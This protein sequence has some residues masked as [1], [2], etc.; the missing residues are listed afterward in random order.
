MPRSTLW[1]HTLRFELILAT[2]GASLWTASCVVSSA[3]SPESDA[4]DGGGA[5]SGGAAGRA[6]AMAGSAGSTEVAG[7][8]GATALDAGL[9]PLDGGGQSDGGPDPLE[10]ACSAYCAGVAS[11]NDRGDAGVCDPTFD[12]E[13]CNLGCVAVGTGGDPDCLD[14]YTAQTACFATSTFS[15]RAQFVEVDL[16]PCLSEVGSLGSCS[17]G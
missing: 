1:G 17:G 2:F 16:V 9:G 15:C 14:E 5:S 13:T 7:S 11:F 12:L 3:A 6:G 10:A 4:G 8:G